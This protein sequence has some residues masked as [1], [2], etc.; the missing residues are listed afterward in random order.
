MN[1][2]IIELNQKV[3]K[4]KNI[5]LDNIKNNFYIKYEKVICKYMSLLNFKENVKDDELFHEKII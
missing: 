1:S 3:A 2:K 4:N 5:N